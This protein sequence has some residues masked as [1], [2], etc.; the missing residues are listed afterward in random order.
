M[1]AVWFEGKAGECCSQIWDV[2]WLDIWHLD[3]AW[4]CVCLRML[5]LGGV[6]KFP[7]DWTFELLPPKKNNNNDHFVSGGYIHRSTHEQ[8]VPLLDQHWPRRMQ[9]VLSFLW[10]PSIC[11]LSRLIRIKGDKVAARKVNLKAYNIWHFFVDGKLEY[12]PGSF[13]TPIHCELM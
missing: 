11:S 4:I 9:S 3:I 12:P 1:A 6:D 2:Q 13:T 10:S 8:L 7:P 5:L